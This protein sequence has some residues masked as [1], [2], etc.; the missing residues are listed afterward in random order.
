MLLQQVQEPIR[1]IRTYR[2]AEEVRDQLLDA[3]VLAFDTETTGLK[4]YMDHRPVWLSLCAGGPG[5]AVHKRNFAPLWDLMTTPRPSGEQRIIVAHNAKYDLHMAEHDG[6][7]LLQPFNDVHDTI[8]MQWLLD[9]TSQLGLKGLAWDRLGVKMLSF[10]ETFADVIKAVGIE[11]AV[12]AAPAYRVVPYAAKD[13][14]ATYLLWVELRKLLEA[15]W[16]KHRSA[17][18]YFCDLEVAFTAQLYGMERAG[19]PISAEFFTQLLERANRE[20]EAAR[21]VAITVS[22]KADLN[23]RSTKQLRWYFYE[24][25]RYK[26]PKTT[27]GGEGST[28]K[29][30]LA[31]FEAQGEPLARA[32]RDMRE[33]DTSRGTFIEPLTRMAQKRGRV[34]ST[35]R[36]TGA[37]TGRI[38]SADPNLMNIPVRKDPYKIRRAFITDEGYILLVLDYSQLEVRVA[39]HVSNDEALIRAILDGLDLHALTAAKIYGVEYAEILEAKN[40][41]DADTGLT[42]R[43]IKLVKFRSDSKSAVFGSF[44]GIGKRKLSQDTGLTENECEMLLRG[45]SDAY[46]GL[47]KAARK[48]RYEAKAHG[49]VTTIIGRRRLIPGIDSPDKG[50]RAQAERQSFNTLIQGGAADIVRGAMIGLFKN[51]WFRDSGIGILFQVHDELGFHVER[52]FDLDDVRSRITDLMVE[53]PGVSL[54]VPLKVSGRYANNWLE[55]K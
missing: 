29:E 42:D 3:P 28:D 49:Y 4:P 8:V 16:F 5:Y 31:I 45:L 6:A 46:P 36:Q 10:R 37:R 48:A 30:V 52:A 22:G 2:E 25:K 13:A 53:V 1:H 26:P 24:H 14:I 21:N 47:S 43:Q 54:S 20:F 7:K 50:I 19:V 35:W 18:D 38:S 11:G 41:D 23:P 40:A 51:P 55:A 12:L 33:I 32:I 15:T 34:H 39:A 27:P 17:Y 9:D 44:Y